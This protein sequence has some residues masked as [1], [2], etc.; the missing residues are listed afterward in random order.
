[1]GN[2]IKYMD[3]SMRIESCDKVIVLIVVKVIMIYLY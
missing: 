3:R 2:I 1:M